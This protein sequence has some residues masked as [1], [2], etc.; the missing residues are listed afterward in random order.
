MSAQPSLD[1]ESFETVLASAFAVQQSGM[2]NESRSALIAI[3]RS[4]ATG[5]LDLDQTM[6]LIADRARNIANATGI[7][8]ALLKA[9]QLVY[10][11]ASGS[12]TSYVGRQAIAVLSVSSHK[13][14]RREILRV[15][16]AQ[17]DPR[18]E[19]AICRQFG[20]SSLLIL[21]I[22]HEGDV[23][24]VLEVFFSE[25]HTFHHPEVQ[26]YQLMT[27]LVEK[28]MFRETQLDQKESLTSQLATVP[29][30]MKPITSQTQKLCGSD[31]F[32]PQ[33]PPTSWVDRLRA[34]MAVR[35]KIAGLGL[36][37]TGTQPLKFPLL[38]TLRWNLLPAAVVIALV[39]ATWIVRRPASPMER[40]AQGSSNAAGS[41]VSSAP[42]RRL[43]GNHSSKP[44]T[45][46]GTERHE[47]VSRSAFK[48][49]RIGQNEID[50]VAEDV[51]V[52]HFTQGPALLEMRRRSK[53]I[54]I[55]ED[56]TVRY[57][58]YKP[59]VLRQPA[60]VSVSAQSAESPPPTSK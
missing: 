19:A 52:R 10:R 41:Q 45:A 40:S 8:I 9:T 24:G 58:E 13:S 15:E 35:K 21:P 38:E 50:Y 46:S 49:V 26:I 28:A 12:A 18:I 42:S 1:R 25:P 6:R 54:N 43:P 16:D 20:A 34:K 27:G 53:Q 29:H 32:G 51:T 17:S 47:G 44:R 22:Y 60:P 4:I 39:I 31:K 7:A 36:P 30:P 3:Q 11:A 56:V 33:R 37:A 55:G 14:P 23:A 48:R 57:F 59:A 2:D 5:E